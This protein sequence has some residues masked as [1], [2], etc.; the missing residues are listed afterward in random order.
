M[1]IAHVPWMF[2]CILVWVGLAIGPAFALVCPHCGATDLAE[3]VLVCPD[4]GKDVHKVEFHGIRPSATY[5]AIDLNY[6]G[7]RFHRLP[8]YGKVYLNNRY[9][10]NIPLVRSGEADADPAL[11]FS[12]DGPPGVT[13][14]YRREW[15]NLQAGQVKIEVKLRFPRM[16]GMAHSERTLTF[17]FAQLKAG[18]KTILTHRFNAMRSFGA[19]TQNPVPPPPRKLPVEFVTGSGTARLEAGV[20]E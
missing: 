19:R 7:R 10:G 18:E 8:P 16:Y 14:Q 17:P 3:L 11:R 2:F 5:L 4:C 13:G 6:L 1:R 20:F 12:K 9:I 15:R